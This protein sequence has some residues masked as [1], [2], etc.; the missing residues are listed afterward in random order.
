MSSFNLNK[1]IK[2]LFIGIKFRFTVLHVKWK[3][4]TM[5][6]SQ[7]EHGIDNLP[8]IMGQILTLLNSFYRNNSPLTFKKA[9]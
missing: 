3:R 9:Y 1:K 5:E 8:Q 6:R 7:F 4:G 2:R